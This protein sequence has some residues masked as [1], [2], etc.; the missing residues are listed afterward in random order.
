MKRRKMW[1]R[2]NSLSRVKIHKSR[3][4]QYRLGETTGN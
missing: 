2:K 1:W 4:K 3:L